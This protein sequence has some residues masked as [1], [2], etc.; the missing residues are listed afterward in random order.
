VPPLSVGKLGGYEL[1]QEKCGKKG[2]TTWLQAE[3][4]ARVELKGTQG[5]LGALKPGTLNEFS[6][7]GSKEAIVES[8]AFEWCDAG[9]GECEEQGRGQLTLSLVELDASTRGILATTSEGFETIHYLWTLYLPEAGKFRQLLE[10][11]S[12]RHSPPTVASEW[13][14]TRKGKS[15]GYYLLEYFYEFRDAQIDQIAPDL[16][17]QLFGLESKRWDAATKSFGPASNDP[18]PVWSLLL[19]SGPGYEAVQKEAKAADQALETCAEAKYK[20]QMAMSDPFKK[21]TK[22]TWIYASISTDKAALVKREQEL[23]KCAPTLKPL[24]KQAY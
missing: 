14:F 16:A 12:G 13:G 19:A 8:K 1:L 20:F 3:G 9:E 21:L 6:G 24:L 18:I 2:C 15:L 7:L 23:A 10:G 11:K 17:M 4:G 22:G 5:K